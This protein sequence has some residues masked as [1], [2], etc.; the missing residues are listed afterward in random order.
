[1]GML[2][3]L[4]EKMGVAG[5]AASAAEH[6]RL[7]L[8]CEAT[9]AE[10]KPRIDNDQVVLLDVRDRASFA[11]EHIPGSWNIPLE[12]LPKNFGTLPRHKTIV[13][14]GWNIACHLAA[15]AAMELAEKGF[16]AQ[17][18][19]GGVDEWKKRGFEVVGT[20]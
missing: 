17:E 15:Q 7:K 19:V 12:E 6:F 16:R 5:T 18:L 20:P 8:E 1:M 9:P 2:N 11:R 10:L 13:A 14:Y 4:K 3:A